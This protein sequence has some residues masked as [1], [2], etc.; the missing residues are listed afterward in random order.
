MKVNILVEDKP[1]D[2][3]FKSEFGLSMYI[4][5][6]GKNILFDVG[7]SSA[8]YDNAKLLN[9]DLEEVDYVILSHGHRDH[10]GGLKHM[11]PIV[12]KSE[13]YASQFIDG[14]YYANLLTKGLTYIG[15]DK[16][17]DTSSFKKIKEDPIFITDNIAIITNKYEDKFKPY[18]NK[19]LFQKI[20]QKYVLDDFS[21]EIILVIRENG[22]LVIF[23]G[24]SH[25]GITNMVNS[26]KDIFPDCPVKGV[27]GGFHLF[28]PLTKITE[29]IDVLN[30]LA[31]DLKSYKGCTFYTGHC[32]GDKAFQVL[33]KELDQNLIRFYT[34]FGV[35]I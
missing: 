15:I 10:L 35:E 2:E 22:K 31:N 30:N 21:H 25:S 1:V 11:M 16:E 23:T 29:S 34:G 20:D 32:T 13:V 18:G 3:V 17:I 27:F 6:D 28:N 9:I 24:C 14:E 19:S 33:K 5:Y 7:S 4:E 8:I 26:A 12:K